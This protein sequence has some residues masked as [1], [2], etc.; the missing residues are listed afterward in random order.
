M[1][2][3]CVPHRAR[4]TDDGAAG[5]SEGGG[6]TAAISSAAGFG[7]P[8]AADASPDGGAVANSESWGVTVAARTAPLDPDDVG[9]FS[10]TQ[11]LGGPGT[12]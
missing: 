12:S 6:V 5:V 1:N 4:G 10:M 8:G 11:P 9:T 7:A 3:I 2:V